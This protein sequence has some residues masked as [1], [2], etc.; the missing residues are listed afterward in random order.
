MTTP[1]PG[2]GGRLPRDHADPPLRLVGQGRLQARCPAC[3]TAGLQRM[4]FAMKNGDLAE[5]RR[6]GNCEWR[7]WYCNDNQVA[8]VD[9][10]SAVSSSGLPHAPR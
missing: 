9:V 5:L 2:P 1:M 10:L 7:S 3:R 4:S 8:L 6:C